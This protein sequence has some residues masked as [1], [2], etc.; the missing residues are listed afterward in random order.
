MTIQRENNNHLKE[1]RNELL[2][3][4]QRLKTQENSK[5]EIQEE[6]YTVINSF[7]SEHSIYSLLLYCTKKLREHR[8]S[9]GKK[10]HYADIHNKK[11]W[12]VKGRY[13]YKFKIIY[14]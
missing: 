7:G 10:Q 5:E 3:I 1:T 2:N 13:S 8:I 12:Y 9:N 4:L 14:L 11:L 6:I